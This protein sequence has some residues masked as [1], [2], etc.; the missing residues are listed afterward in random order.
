MVLVRSEDNAAIELVM[1]ERNGLFAPSARPD[2]L[3]PAMLRVHGAGQ[4]V[5]V[6]ILALFKER[7]RRLS[8]DKSL[9][10]VSATDGG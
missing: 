8:L 3:S 10:K 7:A 4:E 1:E 6:S 2:D 5:R 9:E